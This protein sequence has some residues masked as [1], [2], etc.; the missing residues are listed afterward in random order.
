MKIFCIILA[1]PV[2]LVN[3]LCAYGF[4]RIDFNKQI[5]ELV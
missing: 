3:F 1:H 2:I 4:V 5:Y